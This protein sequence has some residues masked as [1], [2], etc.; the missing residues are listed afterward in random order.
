MSSAPA[1]KTDGPPIRGAQA[2]GRGWCTTSAKRGEKE[3]RSW[4]LLR[5]KEDTLLPDLLRLQ[6]IKEETW[7]SP[8]PGKKEKR[9]GG[10]TGQQAAWEIRSGDLLPHWR[11]DG[12]K[13]RERRYF[14]VYQ[15]SQKK[16]GEKKSGRAFV[17]PKTGGGLLNL[18]LN[19]ATRPEK[20]KTWTPLCST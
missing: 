16:G 19:N 18:H 5:R 10:K 20:K 12:R 11:P 15:Y 4:P 1:G 13:K 8:S 14:T 9:G 2:K 3:E 17:R 7:P 6:R